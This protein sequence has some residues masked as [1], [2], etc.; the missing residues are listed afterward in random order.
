M[1]PTN[2]CVIALANLRSNGTVD[3]SSHAGIT[4]SD[5]TLKLFDSAMKE[6][7]TAGLVDFDDHFELVSNDWRNPAVD[8]FC[9]GSSTS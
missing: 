1:D 2:P 4:L 7:L 5:T 6:R 3:S 9:G 8:E